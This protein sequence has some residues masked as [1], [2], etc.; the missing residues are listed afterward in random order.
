MRDAHF[1]H[2][3]D[4]VP[5]SLPQL[6][7]SPYSS[8]RGVSA[9]DP[10]R[11]AINY[12][13][14]KISYARLLDEVEALA[15]YLVDAGIKPG[16]RVLLCLQNAP[17]FV[18]GF[19]AISAAGAIV[20]PVNPMNRHDEIA[21][22]IED[23]GAVLMIVGQEKLPDLEG[24]SGGSLKQVIVAVY[25][26]YLPGDAATTVAQELAVPAEP[27][28]ALGFVSWRRALDAD[29]AAELP[30]SESSAAS[31]MPYTSG[32]TGHPKGCVHINRTTMTTAVASALWLGFSEAT[33]QLVTLPLFHVTGMHICMIGGLLR[34]GTLHI[35]TRWDRDLAID[36]IER[37]RITTWIAISAMVIDV[38]NVEGLD[39]RDL[40]SLGMIMGGG[41]AMPEAVAARLHALTGLDYIE[42]YGLSETSAPVMINPPQR[43]RRGCLGIPLME[44]DAR[45][46]DVDTQ[47]ELPPGETGEIVVS[48]PQVFQGY[49]QRPDAS[50]EA[51]I[52]LDG[53]RFL[54]TGDLGYCDA[55]GYFYMVDRLKRMINAAGYKV[56]PAEIEAMLFQHPGI[57]EA[58]VISVP[59]ERRGEAVSAV[60]VRRSGDEAA[61]EADII[62]W[63]RDRMSAYKVPRSVT[64]VDELPKS[65]TGKVMW[66]VIEAQAWA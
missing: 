15:R 34:G 39:K 11:V 30:A 62:A 45:V 26:D 36:L 17:Q 5:K 33:V 63:C 24:L 13:G 41:A 3:P 8:L 25:S 42:G 44:V 22:L 46:L 58:C 1:S 53:K 27:V 64:F 66:R 10:S 61:E 55:D 50:E 23:T 28:T 40:S 29:S 18:I 48:A 43:P 51:L 37:N 56:W 21:Y 31:T 60:V 12:C 59:D 9:Q 65:G 7:E 47:H 38:V 2:W 52:T 57:K 19:Y 32:T 6:P 49:W 35:M 20:V 54:R 4:N 14:T 16:D